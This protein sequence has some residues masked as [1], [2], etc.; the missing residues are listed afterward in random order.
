MTARVDGRGS[1]YDVYFPTV[2]LHSYVRP[3]EGD[4]P[5]SR[6]HF[7][8][9]TG[10]LAVGRRLDWFTERGAWESFQQYQGATNLLTTKLN[11]RYGPIQVLMTDFV[12]MGECLPVNAGREKSPGQYLKRFFIKNEA[13]EAKKAVFGG[14]YSGRDQRRSRR[15]RIELARHR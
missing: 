11:W 13:D 3:R 6:T 2:G 12:A 1:T 8:A 10:G 14:L 15:P 4:N 7:R 9:I 5:R